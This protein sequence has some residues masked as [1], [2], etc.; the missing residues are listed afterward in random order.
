MYERAAK[1]GA[2]L[3][4][5]SQLGAGTTITAIWREADP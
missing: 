4:I 2:Q 1:I 3:K 5:E